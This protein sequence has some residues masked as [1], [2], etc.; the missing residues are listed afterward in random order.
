MITLSPLPQR[1]LHPS[2]LHAT[3]RCHTTLTALLFVY[4]T[5][6]YPTLLSS[7]LHTLSQPLLFFTLRYWLLNSSTIYNACKWGDA[8]YSTWL[9]SPPPPLNRLDPTLMFYSS[10]SHT[11]V[12]TSPLL[13]STVL[14]H[15]FTLTNSGGVEALPADSTNF[16]ET[17]VFRTPL[18]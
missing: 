2:L 8:L 11:S 9:D 10:L 17:F 5:L 4:P 7:T 15:S 16:W 18:E 3:L 1:P 12:L 13:N 14:L 6:P